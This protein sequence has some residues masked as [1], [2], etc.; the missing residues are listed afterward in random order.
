MKIL[1]LGATGMAGHMISLYFKEC[2]HH[3]VSFSTTPFAHCENIVGNAFDTEL[4]KKVIS[5]GKFDG[6]I[7]CIGILNKSA[8]DNKALAVYLNSYLPHQLVDLTKETKT[9]VLHMSTDC[10][11]SGRT[12]NYTEESFRDG[13]TFYDRSK[14]LGEISDSKNLTFRNSIVGPDMYDHGIGLF[15]WFMKQGGTINGY[16]GAMWTGVTTLTL[17]KAM[18]Q[19]LQENLSGL[20]NLVNNS[21]ISK[22]DLLGLFNK[23]FRNNELKIL[24]SD[25][26][27]VN[28]QLVRTRGDFS[29]VVPSYE[30]MISEMYDWV[31]AHIELYPHYYR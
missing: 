6:I 12:G 17:A 27:Q 18:E 24:P 1:V 26:L 30:Q 28:K 21:S 15:N 3:V 13:E 4:L 5:E 22:Y 7:N 29:F 10:V 16:T 9:K 2:G 25:K 14:A 19:A 23:Y 31:M 20:Y 8:E 11:F